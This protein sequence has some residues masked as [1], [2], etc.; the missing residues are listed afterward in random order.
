MAKRY[1]KEFLTYITE[2]VEIP[3]DELQHMTRSEVLDTILAYEGFGEY[4]GYAIRSWILQI[5][6]IDLTNYTEYLD[7]DNV[8]MMEGEADYGK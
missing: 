7:P 4:A 1:P 5:Y 3:E 8:A 2:T 6:G